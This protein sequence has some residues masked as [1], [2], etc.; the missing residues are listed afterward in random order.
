MGTGDIEV[1][2]VLVNLERPDDTAACVASLRELT[3]PVRIV[4]VD[5]GSTDDS[6]ARLRSLR[7]VELVESERNLGFGAGCN[8]GLARLLD[9]AGPAPRYVWILNNDTTVAPDSLAALVAAADADPGLGS[10]SAVLYRADARD[11]VLT[12]GGGRLGRRT[13]LTRDAR[14]PGD[15]VDYLTAAAL[16]VR[17]A[18][19]RE[20]GR[21]D[22]RFF[23]TWEDVDLAVRLEAAG[24]RSAVVPSA[25]VWHAWGGTAAHLSPERVRH[26]ASAAVLFL[27]KTTRFPALTTLPLLGYYATRAARDRAPG[28]LGAAW[29]GWREGWRV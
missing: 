19:L 6:A 17:T 1:G 27:R 2:V 13:G 7:D 21:F 11:E 12:W 22:E 5:N 26:H 10:V 8:L 20:V 24:W 16:L 15:R 18:A 25:R 28:T 23:F 4:V 9:G 3:V 14:G 29:R